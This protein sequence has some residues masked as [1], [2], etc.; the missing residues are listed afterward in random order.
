MIAI[1]EIVGA[2]DSGRLGC[3]DCDFEGQQIGLA[4]G[5]LIH[6][7][8]DD[9]ASRLLIVQGIVLDVTHD[10]LRLDAKG[11][12]SND[13]ACENRVFA[14][15]LEVASVAWVTL[16]VDAAADGHVE[17]LGTE[18]PADDLAV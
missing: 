2:H 3:F 6:A 16:Q 15:V 8:V 17:A 10:V 18:L 9:R 13:I 5:A 4:L 12:L 7:D 1:H 11:E 14:G